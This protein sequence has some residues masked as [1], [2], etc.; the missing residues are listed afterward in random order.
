M[1]TQEILLKR[2]HRQPLSAEEIAEF[3]GGIADGRV[4][5]GQVAA[6]CM[7]PCLNPMTPDERTFLTLAMAHS[8][9]T[10]DWTDADL[11]GPVLDKHSTGGVGDKTSLMI[12]PIVAAC[13]GY[14]PMLSGRGLGH[15]GGTLDKLDSIPGY[16]TQPDLQTIKR[17]VADVGCAIIGASKDLAPADRIMYAIRDVTGTVESLDL[18]TASILSK[19]MAAGLSGLVM[20]V[21]FGSG[22][23]MQ[24]Y[25]DARDLAESIHSV[26]NTGGLPCSVLMTDMNQ[27]LGRSA[28][29]AIEVRE[30][31]AFLRNEQTDQRLYDV[32]ISLCAEM[33]V[34]GKLA[35]DIATARMQCEGV[36]RSGKAMDIFERMVIALG[37]PK[38]IAA[39]Y[40]TLLPRAP[41]TLAVHAAEDGV[42]GT[43]NVRTLGMAVIAL[44]GGR[45]L[46]TDSIDHGVGLADIATPGEKIGPRDA[47]LCVILGNDR[48]SMAKAE[49]LIREAYAIVPPGAIIETP[50]VVRERITI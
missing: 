23:F 3:V 11:S 18:I 2:R 31:I 45:H 27:V 6:F 25:D 32:T 8:G 10:L 19:K 21:K 47:P 14:V 36:L 30:A 28:G 49:A 50:P 46:V 37:G 15:T 39:H 12:A 44:G 26:A 1:L 35:P 22:A 41:L 16:T 24:H 33:L 48:A 13:G 4:S 17:V 40:D 38:S 5:E 9:V 7:A 20:D 42:V 34:L 43:I 29:N